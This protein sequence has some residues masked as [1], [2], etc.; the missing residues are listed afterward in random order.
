M[1]GIVTGGCVAYCGRRSDIRQVTLK[2]M[3]MPFGAMVQCLYQHPSP[4]LPKLNGSVYK[5]VT[6]EPACIP[7]FHFGMLPTTRSASAS[8]RGFF[9]DSLMKGSETAPL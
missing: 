3:R 5:T 8:R 7:G 1:N 4:K 6:G 9:E 2:I